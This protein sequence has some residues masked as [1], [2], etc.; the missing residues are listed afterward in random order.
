MNLYDERDELE[1]AANELLPRR[2]RRR[3]RARARR[4]GG[5]LVTDPLA[6]LYAETGL[7]PVDDKLEL[8]TRT[9]SLEELT[10]E[11]GADDETLSESD[12]EELL[13]LVKARLDGPG[14]PDEEAVELGLGEIVFG[15]LV[16]NAAGKAI[17]SRLIDERYLNVRSSS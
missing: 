13:L 12:L 6:H 9:T 2:A 14:L 11:T 10:A 5:D 4:A 1:E 17:V 7:G 8:P 15:E 16:L 3:G